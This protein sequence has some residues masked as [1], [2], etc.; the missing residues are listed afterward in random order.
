[1]TTI[2]PISRA[3]TVAARVPPMT[4]ISLIIAGGTAQAGGFA[5]TLWEL[6]RTQRREFPDHIPLHHRASAWLRRRLRRTKPKAVE[7]ELQPASVT[8]SASLDL[9][10]GRAPATTLEGRVERLETVVNDLRRKQQ[11]DRAKL[12]ERIAKVSQRVTDSHGSLREHLAEADARRK[13]NLRESLLFQR[14][15]VGMFL[16]GILLTVIGSSVSC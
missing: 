4:C 8:S 16:V 5:L 1:M 12:E 15:G 3:A 6:S 10:V 14:I 7:I 2:Q 13:A 9:E 11:E